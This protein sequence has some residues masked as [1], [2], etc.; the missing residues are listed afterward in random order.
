VRVLAAV[1]V[2]GY[3]LALVAGIAAAVLGS[4]TFA[5][6]TRS[7]PVGLLVALC[8]CF[9]VFVTAGLLLRSRGAAASAVVGW[10]VT[11][12]WLST[13]R[14]EGDLIVPGTTLGYCWL[15]V[16]LA[17]AGLSL[18]VPYAAKRTRSSGTAPTGR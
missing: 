16:G 8:L 2:L 18:A 4:F 12:G 17:V 13:Q 14:P 3:L 6:Q 5:Y 11:V 15:L 1:R 9:A 7:L 10:L